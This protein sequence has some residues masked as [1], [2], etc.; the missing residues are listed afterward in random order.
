MQTGE[1]VAVV[2]LFL[3]LSKLFHKNRETGI[4]KPKLMDETT[5][6]IGDKLCYQPCVCVCVCGLM[7]LRTPK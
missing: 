5:P 1:A 2:S 3:S 7:D 4:A 6:N